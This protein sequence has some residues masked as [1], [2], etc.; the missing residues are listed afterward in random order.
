VPITDAQLLMR[1]SDGVYRCFT[2]PL[3]EHV[4]QHD[5]GSGSFLF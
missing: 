5:S 1:F 2:E 3:C 4:T